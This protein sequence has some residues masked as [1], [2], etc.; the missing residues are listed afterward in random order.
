[1][2]QIGIGTCLPG[3]YSTQR[4]SHMA[5][6][7]YE[8]FSL[9]FH[10]SLQGVDLSR[11]AKE[12][13]PIVKENNVRISALGYYCNPLENSEHRK[14]LEEF[15]DTASEFESPIVSTFAGALE[16]CSVSESIKT[17]SNVFNNLALR[18]KDRDVLIAIENCP[19]KGTWD[20]PTS[21]I[22]IN[23]C[24]WEM[25]FNE[26]KHQ[27]VGL[28]FDPGHLSK[29]LIDPLDAL[30]S[31]ISTKRIFHIHGKDC[32]IDWSAINKNGILGP[33]EYFIQRTPG[34]GDLD[35]RQ[36]FSILQMSGYDS[37]I[38]VEGYHDPLYR[39]EWEM[40]AQIHAYKYLNWC[41]GG[42]FSPNPWGSE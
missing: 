15:I 33:D 31:F 26:I 1:M 37:D 19:M 2:K 34:F 40:T 7:G 30:S 29:Q 41:R 24:S 11:L 10:M 27:N 38:C 18:A 8:C 3:P 12:I 28:E 9:N 39:D 22:A 35:W 14:T 32:N 13:M 4:L 16:G 17:F 21:N 6:I 42:S 25:M 20:K 36:I 23:P 5:K